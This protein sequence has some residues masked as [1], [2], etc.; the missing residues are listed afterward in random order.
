MRVIEEV[1]RAATE[2][3]ISWTAGIMWLLLDP[4]EDSG[5][6]PDEI[7]NTIPKNKTLE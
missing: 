5:G 1:V 7:L 6:I 4:L 3:N 2:F